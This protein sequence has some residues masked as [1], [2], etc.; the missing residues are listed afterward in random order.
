MLEFPFWKD[1]YAFLCLYIFT[2]ARF[3]HT[4]WLD[5]SIFAISTQYNRTFNSQ[6]IH[7]NYELEDLIKRLN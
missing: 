7:V 1:I 6:C 5:I 2:L 4:E 3:E